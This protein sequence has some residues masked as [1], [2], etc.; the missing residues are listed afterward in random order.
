[1]AIVGNPEEAFETAM[2]PNA[3]VGLARLEFII[4]A[5]IKVHP[6]ALVHFDK[7]TDP[8]VRD[9]IEEL[10]VG[11]TDKKQFFV[12]KLAQEAGQIAAAFYPKPVIIRMSD[13]KS[14]EYFNLLGGSFFEPEEENPMI[15][16]RGA[17]RYFHEKYR[18]AFALECQAMKKI[19]EEMGLHNVVLMI[20]FV[21]TVPEA[22]QVLAELNRHGLER[23]KNGLKIYMMCEI[24]SNVIMADEFAKLFDGFSIG[25]NDLTQTTLACDRDSGIL[26][27]TFDERD[28]AIKRMLIMAIES[29]NKAGIPIGMCGQAPSDHP[30]IAKFLV[31]HGIKSMSL[32]P[33]SI[34]RVRRLLTE[35]PE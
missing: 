23:G 6:M 8:K 5:G 34:L 24:P 15:G 14:N 10:T 27:S 2:L 29:C 25:S 4:N 33:D 30:E 13:F 28:P 16:F 21:R 20:P 12:D 22:K 35:K 3:G 17:S 31:N 19:R 9:Q 1:M 18:E 11:Y 7:V 26:A 32:N